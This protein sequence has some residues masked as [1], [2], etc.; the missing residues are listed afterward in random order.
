[1]EASNAPSTQVGMI[2]MSIDVMAIVYVLA[3]RL[4]RTVFVLTG[5]LIAVVVLDLAFR[6]GVLYSLF[7]VALASS[8]RSPDLKSGPPYSQIGPIDPAFFT[9]LQVLSKLNL[10]E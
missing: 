7:S 10:L 9:Y 5:S 6:L 3:P 8:S 2:L 4:L 1:M